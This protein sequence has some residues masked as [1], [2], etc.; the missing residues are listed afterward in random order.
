MEI[1]TDNANAPFLLPI[2][3]QMPPV[4]DPIAAPKGTAV[5]ITE[6]KLSSL[7]MT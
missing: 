1:I 2:D 3:D 4:K 6:L 5:V 7:F